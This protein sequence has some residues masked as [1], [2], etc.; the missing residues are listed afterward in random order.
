MSS[1]KDLEIYKIAFN[2]ALKVHNASLKLPQFELYELE[3]KKFKVKWQKLNNLL[4]CG[5]K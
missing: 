5:R 2:L 3:S 4:D 1:F